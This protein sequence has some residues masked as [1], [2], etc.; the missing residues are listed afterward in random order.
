MELNVIHDLGKTIK[1][2]PKELDGIDMYVRSLAADLRKEYFLS[3]NWL[4][5]GKTKEVQ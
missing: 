5:L 1:D 2:D 3:T 4:D